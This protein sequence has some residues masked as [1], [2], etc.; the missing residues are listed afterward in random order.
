M[1]PRATF[2]IGL[3]LVACDPPDNRRR[4]P[5]EVAVSERWIASSRTEQ[6]IRGTCFASVK[7][8]VAKRLERRDRARQALVAAEERLRVAQELGDPPTI[9]QAMKD[10]DEAA[11]DLSEREAKTLDPKR[12]HSECERRLAVEDTQT[13][14]EQMRTER[15]AKERR[16][17][18]RAAEEEADTRDAAEGAA[19]VFRALGAAARGAASALEE[20]PAPNSTPADR[21]SQ[22]IQEWCSFQCSGIGDNC[23]PCMK[24]RCDIQ[25]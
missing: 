7:A 2:L 6:Q 20:P 13:R 17:A 18:A 8:I 22:C 1:H 10:R 21:C 25:C 5:P 3:A 14:L 19:A 16:A 4:P 9:L 15:E 23:A 24:Q 12:L 11:A